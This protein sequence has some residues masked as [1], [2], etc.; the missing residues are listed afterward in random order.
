MSKKIKGSDTKQL[1]L[2]DAIRLADELRKTRTTQHKGA[3]A[4][5]ERDIAEFGRGFVS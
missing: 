5:V 3:N 1:S 2:F 4:K